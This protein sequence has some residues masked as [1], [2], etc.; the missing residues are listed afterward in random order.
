MFGEIDGLLISGDT[1][2]CASHCGRCATP[3]D[4]GPRRWAPT[5]RP[6]GSHAR[7]ALR[8]STPKLSLRVS[9]KSGWG[10]DDAV[11]VP[12]HGD[13]PWERDERRR[14]SPR[15]LR[16]RRRMASVRT[17][18]I[19]CAVL[20]GVAAVIRLGA[21]S[22]GPGAGHGG[23]L[24]G[25]YVAVPGPWRWRWVSVKNPPPGTPRYVRQRYRV[26]KYV[27]ATP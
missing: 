6:P 26:I 12:T 11:S 4:R 10:A 27:S 17:A 9:I 5:G 14:R 21:P 8:R 1:P 3:P 7:A 16:L 18:L 19:V 13:F 22:A 24:P 23:Q 25:A 15:R 2:C 20:V